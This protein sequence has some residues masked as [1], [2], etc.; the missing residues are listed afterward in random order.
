MVLLPRNDQPG[1]PALEATEA[2]QPRPARGDGRGPFVS[3]L[4]RVRGAALVRRSVFFSP[5][6]MAQLTLAAS[7]AFLRDKQL[8]TPT[9]AAELPQ[10]QSQF[11]DVC[12]LA[13]ELVQR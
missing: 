12:G 9:Q 3:T 4:G 1:P 13:R 6:I 8:L 7:V 10:L 2:D 5:Q 11:P